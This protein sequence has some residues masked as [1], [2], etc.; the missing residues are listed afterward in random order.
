MRIIRTNVLVLAAAVAVVVGF[1]L[2][3]LPRAWAGT[4][5]MQ[6]FNVI[7]LGAPATGGSR[8]PVTSFNDNSDTQGNAFLNGSVAGS[9]FA[10][11]GLPTGATIGLEATG[12]VTS[13]NVHVDNGKVLLGGTATG[14]FSV[15]RGG[16]L[17]QNSTAPATDL[18]NF[19]NE[20]T[21]TSTAWAALP[22]TTGA[23][24]TASNNNLTFNLPTAPSL[25]VFNIDASTFSPGQS[26]SNIAFS[27]LSANQQ[28]LINFSGTSFSEPSGLNFNGNSTEA[29]NIVWNFS[30]ATTL[31]LQSGWYGSILAPNATLSTQST[32]TGNLAVGGISSV[33]EID[34]ASPN[35]T[36]PLN[37]IPAGG[38]LPAPSTWALL[39]CGGLGLGG[40]ALGRRKAADKYSA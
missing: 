31:S 20:L 15:N 33:G 25:V 34:L 29:D 26:I 10:G 24:V 37:A 3:G 19:A 1:G 16:S 5:P 6:Q 30:T 22:T 35:F 7:V 21:A 38:P 39:F 36:T 14:G 18:A 2:G 13:S 9:T 11:N 27:T 28:V 4:F 40:L 32:I 23:T 17:T 8:T 12:D